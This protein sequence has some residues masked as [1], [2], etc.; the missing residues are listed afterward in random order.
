MLFI[1]CTD[2]Y[3]LTIKKLYVENKDVHANTCPCFNNVEENE[4]VQL[5]I[6]SPNVDVYR[7]RRLDL[8]YKKINGYPSIL[9]QRD[10]INIYIRLSRIIS[11]MTDKEV[12]T[13]NFEHC[14]EGSQVETSPTYL[15][16]KQLHTPS[17][18]ILVS[19]PVTPLLSKQMQQEAMF[20]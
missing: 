20:S 14:I 6:S 5:L 11:D 3:I 16:L 1:C 8:F 15:P 12:K 13:E 17:F 19:K 9:L 2:T 10:W 7:I 4:F 18:F